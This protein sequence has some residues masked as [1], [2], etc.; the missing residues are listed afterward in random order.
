MFDDL[1]QEL[2][3][4]GFDVYA[5]ADDLAVVGREE[6]RAKEAIDIIEKWTERNDMIINRK[7]SGI[8]FLKKR[9]YKKS[10]KEYD[11]IMDI[12]I[13][14]EYKYLGIWMDDHFS[15]TKQI[16]EIK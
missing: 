15:F 11:H 9:D 1:V 5:Y 6:V 16:M 4:N 14:K 3:D 8:M 10:R 12:P 2:D 7:K 13:V